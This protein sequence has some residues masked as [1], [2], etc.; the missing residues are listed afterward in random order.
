VF[1][2]EIAILLPIPLIEKFIRISSWTMISLI[3]IITLIAGLIHEWN[4][5]ALEWS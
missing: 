2:V 4:F 1:D 5:G 3:F